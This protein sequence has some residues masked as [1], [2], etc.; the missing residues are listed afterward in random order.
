MGDDIVKLEKF[1]QNIKERKSGIFSTCTANF[2]VLDF[3]F[4]Y[5]K[6][7]D[8]KILVESTSNQV[9]QDGG[10]TG[11]KPEDFVSKISKLARKHGIPEDRIILGG[12]HLGPLPWKNLNS[13]IAMEKAKELVWRYVKAGYE[14]IHLDASFKLGDDDHISP[15]LIA[16]RQAEMCEIAEKAAEAFGRKPVYVLGTEVPPAGGTVSEEDY[17]TS[18][19]EFKKTVE[20]SKEA[21]KAKGLHD[22]W[23]RVVAFVVQ[24]GAEFFGNSVRLY[25]RSRVSDL[26]KALNDYPFVFE[27][28]STDFQPPERLAEM[29][30]DGFAILKV[31]PEFTFKY[32]EGLFALSFI[33]N[34]MGFEN[35]SNLK[36]KLLEIMKEN[37]KYWNKYYESPDPVYLK[38][39]LFDRIRYYWT[40]ASNILE[41]LWKN[42]DGVD[43]PIGLI[44]QFFPDLFYD[45]INKVISR[46]ARS[47]L[48]ERVLRSIKKY[49]EV[50]L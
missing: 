6:D 5:M 30:K 1:F 27:A 34:E 39:S 38:Y 41:K 9:N 22:A 24:P 48:K 29:V 7:K 21:F 50:I 3:L 37:P 17:V 40:E 46:D 28:H 44:S 19:D 10:Y 36:D 45:V 26:S 33:E 8:G 20:L 49:H 23:K 31:G 12:D 4:E 25:E 35:P 13:E 32:R 47:L 2:D 43:I 15:E 18:L 14:K 16:K 42:F 11:L